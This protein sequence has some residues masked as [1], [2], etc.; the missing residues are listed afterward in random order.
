M[1]ASLVQGP[2]CDSAARAEQRYG[3]APRRHGAQHLL[4]RCARRDAALHQ[5]RLLAFGWQSGTGPSAGGFTSAAMVN[6]HCL[7]A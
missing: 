2:D 5:A 4:H 3:D 6:K 7:H 1:K